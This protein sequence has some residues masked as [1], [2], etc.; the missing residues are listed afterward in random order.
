LGEKLKQNGTT[1]GGRPLVSQNNE[2]YD[3]RHA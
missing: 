2:N 3:N 1:V